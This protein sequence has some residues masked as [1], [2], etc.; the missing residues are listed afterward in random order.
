MRRR[1][2]KNSQ[3]FCAF[4]FNDAKIL[5]VKPVDGIARELSVLA[6]DDRFPNVNA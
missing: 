5:K 6:V 1:F 2:W 3:L 4:I